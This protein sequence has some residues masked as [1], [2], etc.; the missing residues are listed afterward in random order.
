[1]KVLFVFMCLLMSCNVSRFNLTST[2]V[3]SASF[4]DDKNVECIHN[5]S[6]HYYN[7]AFCYGKQ[8]GNWYFYSGNT[9]KSIFNPV[10]NVKI[11][12][13]KYLSAAKYRLKK[14]IAISDYEGNFIVKFKPKNEVHFFCYLENSSRSLITLNFAK[15]KNKNNDQVVPK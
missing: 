1:M 7:V 9:Q 12:E 6:L 2:S 3:W 10:S 11:V 8:F 15:Q 5:D 14:N 13:A 4:I